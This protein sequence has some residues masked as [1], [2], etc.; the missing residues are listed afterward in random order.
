MVCLEPAE[1]LRGTVCAT[2]FPGVDA[3]RTARGALLP[4]QGGKC[5]RPPAGLRR[6]RASERLSEPNGRNVYG[7]VV[8]ETELTTLRRALQALAEIDDSEVLADTL[9]IVRDP[10]RLS[11]IEASLRL[12]F[13]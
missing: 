7:L 4:R 3:R 2:D 8:T 5:Q 12:P 9:E 11:E 13:K 1:L 6:P 10:L